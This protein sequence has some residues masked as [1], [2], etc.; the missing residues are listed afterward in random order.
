M[1]S[2]KGRRVLLFSPPP[3]KKEHAA[4][5]PPHRER[6]TLSPF[7]PFPAA[8]SKFSVSKSEAP[9]DPCPPNTRNIILNHESPD[10]DRGCAPDH[11]AS[12]CFP[13]VLFCPLTYRRDKLGEEVARVR[14]SGRVGEKERTYGAGCRASLCHALFLVPECKHEG[15]TDYL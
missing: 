9:I 11:L 14:K 1:K 10:D 3:K 5:R 2:G 6:T 15:W 8:S 7:H 4:S 13:A 12:V